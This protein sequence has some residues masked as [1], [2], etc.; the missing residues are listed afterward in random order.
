MFFAIAAFL[1]Q[2]QIVPQPAFSPEKIALI[3]PAASAVATE[4]NNSLRP[5]PVDANSGV[6]AGESQPAT[7]ASAAS[8]PDTPAPAV[9]APVAA[10][11]IMAK[12][13][14]PMTVSVGE[15]LKENRRNQRIWR[16]LVIASSGAATFDAW[17]TRHAITTQGAQELNPLLK[18]FAGN[19]SLFLAIQV[20]PAIMDYAA[21]KMMYSRHGWVRHM[22]WA[23]QTASIVSSLFCG[24]RNLGYH[25]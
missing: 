13:S 2:P 23:P 10:A 6:T 1:I 5:A 15:L 22:W 19:A 7:E 11:F 14:K 17:S 20:G 21:R 25:Q 3:E 8:L 12:P 16:G 4:S 24:A 18:P 9:E